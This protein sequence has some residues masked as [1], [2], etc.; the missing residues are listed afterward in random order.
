MLIL[1][2]PIYLTAIIFYAGVG[3]IGVAG[4]GYIEIG[5]NEKIIRNNLLLMILIA[6]AI[7]GL[8]S[9]YFPKIFPKGYAKQN[10]A[11]RIFLPILFL[12][13]SFAFT[14]GIFLFANASFGHQTVIKVEGY[15]EKKWFKRNRKS[16]DYFLGLRDTV[17]GKYYEFQVKENIYDQIGKRGDK[18]AKDFYKGSLGIIY[19]YHY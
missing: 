18:V 2:N 17:S 7:G 9:Y 1:H 14:V 11:G 6:L 5:G 12:I 3:G 8:V 19:R 16:N 13:L 4:G 15:I 10:K